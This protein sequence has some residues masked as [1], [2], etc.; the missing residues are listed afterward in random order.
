M[1]A[2]FISPIGKGLSSFSKRALRS[3]GLRDTDSG[4]VSEEQLRLVVGGAA[5]S[6]GIEGCV[7]VAVALAALA[8]PRARK[9]EGGACGGRACH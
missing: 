8:C 6:G 3:V 2:I 1:L 5:E 9:E 4:V 7:V